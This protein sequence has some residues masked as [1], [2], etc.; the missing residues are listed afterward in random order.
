MPTF[1]DVIDTKTIDDSAKK[2]G[3]LLHDNGV[4][5]SPETFLGL[6]WLAVGTHGD[7]PTSFQDH[8]DKFFVV[9][10]AMGIHYSNLSE[11]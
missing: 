5:P 7:G 6:I 11:N 8:T 4:I 9:L 1:N 10:K 2:L 3:K